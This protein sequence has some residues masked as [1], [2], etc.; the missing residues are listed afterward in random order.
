M[1]ILV[2]GA[3]GFMGKN[4]ALRLNEESGFETVCFT[5]EDSI[6]ELRSKLETVDAVV[7]LAGENRPKD[8]A[9]FVDGNANLTKTLCDEIEKTGRP[10]P[11]IFSSSI[12]A[13]IDNLYGNSKLA[14]EQA[15]E[16]LEKKTG[17]P[18]KIYRL[19]NVFGKW[20]KANY[21]SV[22]ATFCY[23]VA[24]SL[25]LRIDD[26]LAQIHLVY[27]DDVITEILSQLRTGFSGLSFGTVEPEY[28]ISVGELADQIN[29]F[30]E[31]R[32]SLIIPPV[33]TGLTRALYATYVSFLPTSSFSHA[34]PAYGDERGVFVEMLKTPDC[35]QF[36]FFTAH[37]NIT[38]GGHYHHSKTEKF[39]VIKGRAHFGFRHLLTDEY[40]ELIT[41]GEEP[42][43]VE[44][45]P[46]WAHDITN[47]GEDEMVVML[48]ANE[49]FDRDQPDTM[50][51]KV[52]P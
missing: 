5:R 10:I 8:P 23:N 47:I 6:S 36:S 18:A 33:G 42:Q 3:S 44:T 12:Q 24:R 49:I 19:P 43:I 15:I 51:S 30:A 17:T 25:P 41:A 31:S 21:N 26:P 11:V 38:R 16:E 22:V 1:R 37:P 28:S 48:W 20:S 9:A 35:G 29:T 13:A 14:A 27:I 46:G 40:V 50:A 39:L 52:K 2:T 34:I 45:I 7:H 4:L 32:T